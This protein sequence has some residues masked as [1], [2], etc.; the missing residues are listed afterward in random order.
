[1]SIWTKVCV[2]QLHSRGQYIG[3]FEKDPINNSST[4]LYHPLVNVGIYVC[5]ENSEQTLLLEILNVYNMLP[6]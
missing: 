5:M 4:S 2:G 6:P 3:E 1:M